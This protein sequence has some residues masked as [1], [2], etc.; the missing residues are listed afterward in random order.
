MTGVVCLKLAK[1]GVQVAAFGF[2]SGFLLERNSHKLPLVHDLLPSGGEGAPVSSTL[3]RITGLSPS[4]NTAAG[5]G[6]S[7]GPLG[8]LTIYDGAKSSGRQ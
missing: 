3:V 6:P 8:A 4:A 7:R 2:A 5:T 1:Q